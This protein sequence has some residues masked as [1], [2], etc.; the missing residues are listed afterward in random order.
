M[1]QEMGN[2]EASVSGI[3]LFMMLMVLKS[4]LSSIPYLPYHWITLEG[5]P[6]GDSK[7]ELLRRPQVSS[8]VCVLRSRNSIWEGQQNEMGG[9]LRLMVLNSERRDC[10]FFLLR[11][12]L[13]TFELDLNSLWSPN[14]P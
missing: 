6:Q 13:A 3:N 8:W 1:G 12:G 14:W 9:K 2:G 10:Y 4:R 5:G 7:E 11:H